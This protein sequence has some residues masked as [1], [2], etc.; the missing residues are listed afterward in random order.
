[1]TP[2]FSFL[3]ITLI[4]HFFATA[5]ISK[6]H[7]SAPSTSSA[8]TGTAVSEDSHF[9]LKDYSLACLWVSNS[10]A[11]LDQKNLPAFCHRYSCPYC[12][13]FFQAFSF[14]T[15]V[16]SCSMFQLWS[17]SFSIACFEKEFPKLSEKN[18][19]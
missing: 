14:F 13:L 16:L 18:R 9:N 17:V 19:G 3:Q 12:L 2:L 11:L 15:Q 6:R 4:T 1:M 7:L 10:L 5:P 8:H